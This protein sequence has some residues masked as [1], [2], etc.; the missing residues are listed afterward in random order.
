MVAELV[1][2][3]VL[4][5]LALDQGQA[6]E[7][8]RV[9]ARDRDL[10]RAADRVPGVDLAQGVGLELELELGQGRERERDPGVDRA[11]G[12][13]PDPALEAGV[14]PGA[15][16]GAALEAAPVQGIAFAIRR[17]STTRTSTSVRG[18]MK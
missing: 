13:D 6:A 18:V 16:A 3:V 8:E 14:V 2:A 11:V 4:V 9:E 1:R 5:V 7:R 15:G 17:V 10:A 12:P